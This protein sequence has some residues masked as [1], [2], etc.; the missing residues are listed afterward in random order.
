M[1]SSFLIF[2]VNAVCVIFEK[3]LIN[4]RHENLLLFSFKSFIA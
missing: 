2:F 1:K 4:L 3:P